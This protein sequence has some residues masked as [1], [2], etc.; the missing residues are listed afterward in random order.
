MNTP[1]INRRTLIRTGIGLS[2]AALLG[3]S[4]S[5]AA[6]I[7]ASTECE[8][9]APT[10][11]RQTAG[12]FFTPNTPLRNDFRAD[13]PDGEQFKLVGFVRSRD[14]STIENALIELWHA[15]SSGVYDNR[16]YRMRGHQYTDSEGRFVFNT[17]RPGLYPGRTPHF[18]ITI[19]ADGIRTLTTQL[20]FPDIP[21]NI[22][23]GI[24]DQRLLMD[25]AD[26]PN[27]RIGR[28][29]FTL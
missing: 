11:P 25:I 23:D 15:D 28:Y 26:A 10:T 2:A 5:S 16:G 12:P 8:A 24:F 9:N 6:D 1:R 22:R 18:H 19:A 14:C 4:A 20:Y 3:K 7:L 21:Q 27:E 13:D 29:D 17:T